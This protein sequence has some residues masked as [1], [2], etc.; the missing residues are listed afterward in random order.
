MIANSQKHKYQAY[1]S[2]THTVGKTQQII[3]LYDGTI[4]LLQQAKEAMSEKRI[5]DRFHLLIKASSIIQGLQGCL[6]F[7]N[8]KEIA[9]VLYN[10]YSGVDNKLFAL[11][12][13][14]SVEDC[15]EIIKDL[16]QMRDAWVAVDGASAPQ[17][18]APAASA[19]QAEP[20]PAAPSAPQD[21]ASI[22][23]S[24]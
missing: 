5:E 7:E 11:H 9:G 3:M 20:V 2:A 12:R 17:M 4:R 8:G 24:A 16:K 1:V 14:N 19:A 15:E 22:T 21:M 18:P 13:S 10:F 23:L 6:D